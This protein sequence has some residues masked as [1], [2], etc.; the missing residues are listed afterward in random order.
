MASVGLP[1]LRAD[2][3]L[4]RYE[5]SC[6]DTVLEVIFELFTPSFT[7]VVRPATVPWTWIV[8]VVVEMLPRPSFACDHD[9]IRAGHQGLSVECAAARYGG[10]PVSHGRIEMIV[11]G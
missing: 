3:A 9:R 10:G 7:A 11:W 8:I 4:E 2:C 6:N 1:A 5:R